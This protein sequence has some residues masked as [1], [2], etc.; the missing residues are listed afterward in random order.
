[1]ITKKNSTTKPIS[2]YIQSRDNWK[3]KCKDRQKK[4]K[5]LEAKVKDLIVSRN[6][7]KERA[8]ELEKP[9]LVKQSN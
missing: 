1:M 6:K 2:Y 8:K 7:W 5:F 3:N 4:I 9:M